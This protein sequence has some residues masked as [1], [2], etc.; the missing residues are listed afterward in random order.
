MSKR[1]SCC[2]SYSLMKCLHCFNIQKETCSLIDRNKDSI[3]AHWENGLLTADFWFT[4]SGNANRI[5]DK[6]GAKLEKSS[7]LFAEQLF[8]GYTAIYTVDCI[9]KYASS[10]T[11]N[12]K[13]KNAV[14]MLF[15]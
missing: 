1:A 4:L 8:D 5:I 2:T 13:F 14:A 15:M 10:K 11:D 12:K 3:K 9:V 6:Y 7:R